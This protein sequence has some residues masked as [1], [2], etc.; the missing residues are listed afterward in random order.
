M[1]IH[2]LIKNKNAERNGFLASVIL[3]A[4]LVSPV[5]QAQA[6]SQEAFDP[7]IH[8]PPNQTVKASTEFLQGK[9]TDALTTVLNSP[10]DKITL[11]VAGNIEV[12]LPIP[13]VPPGIFNGGV[14]VE[15]TPEIKRVFNEKD[16]KT[17]YQASWKREAGLS[18]GAGIPDL[19]D[20]TD[21]S[22]SASVALSNMEVF[23]F[24]SPYEAAQGIIDYMVLRGLWKQ[25]M[26]MQNIGIDIRDVPGFI[27]GVRASVRELTGIDFRLHPDDLMRAIQAAGFA[28]NAAEFEVN[29]AGLVVT[30]AMEAFNIALVANRATQTNLRY[31]QNWVNS[32]R[33][34]LNACR[35]FCLSKQVALN[36]ATRALT[37]ARNAA[38]VYR[39]ALNKARTALNRAQD[40]LDQTIAAFDQAEQNLSNLQSQVAM[41]PDET[42]IDPF[43]FVLE[44][45]TDRIYFL[46]DRHQGFEI[47][48]I[49]AMSAQAKIACLAGL[50][51]KTAR[52]FK[53]TRNK[54]DKT[55]SI[56][57]NASRDNSANV[58][59]PKLTYAGVEFGMGANI[60]YEMKFSTDNERAIP[61]LVG[62][63]TVKVATALNG[64]GTA[65]SQF[66]SGPFSYNV[67]GVAGASISPT[68]EIDLS[69]SAA[70]MAANL[71]GV[72]NV[73]PLV[74]E[75]KAF[76]A[77]NGRDIY[78]AVLATLQ[79]FDVNRLTNAI[80]AQSLP[81]TI[82]FN[83]IAGIRGKVGGGQ[84]G[85]I[86]GE[87]SLTA[88]W[89]DAGE[90]VDLS[91]MTVGDFFSS[92][93]EGREGVIDAAG[94]LANIIVNEQQEIDAAF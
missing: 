9:I 31:I 56:S 60:E 21:L 8:L 2:I 25:I 44:T 33:A 69:E 37:A 61:E 39:N 71:Q 74:E 62:L 6:L 3:L 91:E 23:R 13:Y 77:I 93:V 79:T 42:V 81:L 10:E 83:R 64:A 55:L 54:F 15:V 63:G 73:T 70:D 84:D 24:N 76:P 35:R 90:S 88:I 50:E 66:C 4:S 5:G 67:N 20:G 46:V 29:A 72:I 53:L 19:P 38:N 68:L 16:G 30:K 65:G 87:L 58:S 78:N 89:T 92:I 11:T 75:L 45:I 82:E 94:S 59:I 26:L 85:V 34:N 1:N 49:K 51:V 86:K 17:Y 32:A 41:L 52:V 43:N 48:Y 7:A 18:V 40:K 28:L 47:E 12:P 22:A 57:F 27:D 14:S 80:A 36:V